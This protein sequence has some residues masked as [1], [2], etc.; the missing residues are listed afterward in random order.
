MTACGC[1]SGIQEGEAGGLQVQGQTALPN[2]ALG[3]Y[4]KMIIYKT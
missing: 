2:K 3:Q 1:N 4:N